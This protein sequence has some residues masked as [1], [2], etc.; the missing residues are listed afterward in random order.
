[1]FSYCTSLEKT[2]ALPATTLAYGCYEYM[3]TNCTSL[4]KAPDLLA[5]NLPQRCYYNMFRGCE[6]LSYV[7]CF[8]ETFSSSSTNYWLYGV[9]GVGKFVRKYGVIWVP[10]ASGV[11]NNWVIIDG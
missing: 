6:N 11:P 7:K 8:A 4:E 9:F 10:G 2:P 3:F 1:M 5:T